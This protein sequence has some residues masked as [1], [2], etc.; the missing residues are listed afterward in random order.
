MEST[1]EVS[2]EWLMLNNAAMTLVESSEYKFLLIISLSNSRRKVVRTN[3]ESSLVYCAKI[4]LCAIRRKNKNDFKM[5]D[6][7]LQALYMIL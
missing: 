5:Y 1:K 6:F 3:V 7:N 4:K 2:S